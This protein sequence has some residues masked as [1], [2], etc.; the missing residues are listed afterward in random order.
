MI[1]DAINRA[2]DPQH[3]GVT[4]TPSRPELTKQD[5]GPFSDANEVKENIA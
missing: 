4:S 1:E 5:S 3:M 2:R